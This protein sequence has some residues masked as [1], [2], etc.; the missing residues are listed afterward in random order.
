MKRSRFSE[1]RIIM[2]LKEAE[3][4]ARSLIENLIASDVD[5]KLEDGWVNAPGKNR[6]QFDELVKNQQSRRLQPRY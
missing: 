2:M 4:V 1:E 5:A 3:G 6:K